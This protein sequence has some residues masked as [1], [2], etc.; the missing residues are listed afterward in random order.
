MNILTKLKVLFSSMIILSVAFSQEGLKIKADN[1]QVQEDGSVKINVL[2]NDDL[3]DKSNVAIEIVT[4]PEKG[5]VQVQGERSYIHQSQ[6]SLVL[7]SLTTR[8]TTVLRPEPL[9]YE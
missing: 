8:S 2:K 1:A 5:K 3:K 4:E 7:I 6:T 9:R